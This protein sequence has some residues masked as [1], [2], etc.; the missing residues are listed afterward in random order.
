MKRKTIE[1]A[2]DNLKNF[3][4]EN[5]QIAHEEELENGN[6]EV[7]YIYEETKY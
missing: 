4:K 2:H 7:T 6:F 5:I 3:R 1:V